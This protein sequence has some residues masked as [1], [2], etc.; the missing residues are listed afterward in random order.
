[1]CCVWCMFI[2]CVACV[3]RMCLVGGVHDMCIV[4]VLGSVL[5]LSWLVHPLHPNTPHTAPALCMSRHYFLSLLHFPPPPSLLASPFSFPSLLRPLFS[6]IAPSNHKSSLLPQRPRSLPPCNNLPA[7]NLLLIP[8][9]ASTG[10]WT[11]DCQ[12]GAVRAL[13][14]MPPSQDCH[15]ESGGQGEGGWM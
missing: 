12:C 1:M 15:K 7:H 4:L 5:C 13:P 9:P 14:T 8:R 3:H 2:A 11:L 6:C 10:H